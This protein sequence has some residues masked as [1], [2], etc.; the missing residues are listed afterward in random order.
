MFPVLAR[1]CLLTVALLVQSIPTEAFPQLARPAADAYGVE[2]V[3]RYGACPRGWDWNGYRCVQRYG[4]CPRGWD[5]N[6][7][8]CVQRRY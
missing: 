1:V 4:A 3:R 2:L 5:W 8:R 7:Y 6:G